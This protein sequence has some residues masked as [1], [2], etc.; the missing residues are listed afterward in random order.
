MSHCHHSQHITVIKSG[1]LSEVLQCNYLGSILLLGWGDTELSSHQSL[2]A[3]EPGVTI[4]CS[5]TSVT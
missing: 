1:F 4:H 5:E 2:A 3:H